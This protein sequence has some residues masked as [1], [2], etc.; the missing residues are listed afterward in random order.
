MNRHQGDPSILT[1]VTQNRFCQVVFWT[2]GQCDS[3]ALEVTLTPNSNCFPENYG[4]IS[5]MPNLRNRKTPPI[6]H[7]EHP[8]QS[9]M[10]WSWTSSSK[11]GLDVSSSVS[12]QSI[13][14]FKIKELLLSNYAIDASTMS[15]NIFALF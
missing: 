14:T 2:N 11:A 13:E 4:N 6:S 5:K 8:A 1:E 3:I 10:L 15:S 12:Q 7:L 9:S